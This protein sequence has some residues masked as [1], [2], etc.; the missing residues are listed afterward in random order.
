MVA[1]TGHPAVQAGDPE[2]LRDRRLRRDEGETAP[3]R[4]GVVGDPDEGAEPAGVAEGQA[5][6]IEQQ[7]PSQAAMAA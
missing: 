1:K 5:G 4:V 2:D 3:C 7:Q 6:Q